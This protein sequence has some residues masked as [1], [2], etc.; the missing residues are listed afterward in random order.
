VGKLCLA[1]LPGINRAATFASGIRSP[2]LPNGTVRDSRMLLQ[3]RR[4]YRAE[5]RSARSHANDFKRQRQA[6]SYIADRI[7]NRGAKLTGGS[8]AGRIAGVHPGFF[9]VL[10]DRD[11]HVGPSASESTSISWLPQE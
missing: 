1:I 9:K 10:H 11:D 2:L 6:R 8:H 4:P 3:A 7:E 5:S